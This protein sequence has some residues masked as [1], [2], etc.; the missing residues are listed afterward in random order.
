MLNKMIVL[1]VRNFFTTSEIYKPFERQYE[2]LR[3]MPTKYQQCKLEDLSRHP[4]FT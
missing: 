3:K 1:S 2:R 4:A